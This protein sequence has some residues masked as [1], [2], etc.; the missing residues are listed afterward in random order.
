MPQPEPESDQVPP[1]L[2]GTH[3]IIGKVYTE[4]YDVEL[5]EHAPMIRFDLFRISRN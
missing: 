5:V 4:C 1:L 2:L 3:V